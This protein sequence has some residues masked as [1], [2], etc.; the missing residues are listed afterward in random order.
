[1]TNLLKRVANLEKQVSTH[2]LNVARQNE[3]TKNE[4]ESG[5]QNTSKVQK[6]ADLN[7]ESILKTNESIAET[8]DAFCEYSAITEESVAMIEDAMCELDLKSDDRLVTIE[9]VL[10][11]LSRVIEMEVNNMAKIW[12]NRII[13]G[14][15]VFADCPDRYKEKTIKLLQDD[16]KNGVIT[17]ERYKEITGEEYPA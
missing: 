15:Q 3:Y 2:I 11:E 10:C 14:T 17:V 13:A 7:E 8:Q 5:M 16:V 4:I 1:M 6:K 9:D 12:R